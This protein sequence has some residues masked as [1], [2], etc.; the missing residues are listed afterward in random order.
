MEP[1]PDAI[2]IDTTALT[3]DEVVD[4]IEVLVRERSPA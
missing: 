4:R 1:A 2:R 3:V